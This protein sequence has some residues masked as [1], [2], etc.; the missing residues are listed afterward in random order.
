MLFKNA[1]IFVDGTFR[2]GSFRVEDGKF[3]EILDT[4]PAEE[5]MDLEGKYVIPGLIDVITTATPMPTSPT[6]TTKV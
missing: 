4:V 6:V 3:V 2:H 1:F 5:G